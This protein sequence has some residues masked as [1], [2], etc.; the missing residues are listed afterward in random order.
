MFKIDRLYH[1][2]NLVC[3]GSNY[4]QKNTLFAQ[5]IMIIYEFGSTYAS[6]QLVCFAIL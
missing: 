1:I 4:R 6:Y 3:K 2:I 5:I